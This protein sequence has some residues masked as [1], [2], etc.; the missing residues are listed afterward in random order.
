MVAG[1]AGQATREV[2][3]ALAASISPAE[4]AKTQR[5]IP[6]RQKPCWIMRQEALEV[7]A[8]QILGLQVRLEG[9]VVVVVVAAGQV[10]QE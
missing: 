10:I 9:L 7:L 8:G 5:C 4:Q 1:Q 6:T 3:R 2:L